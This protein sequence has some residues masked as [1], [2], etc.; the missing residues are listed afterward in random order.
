MLPGRGPGCSESS[1]ADW[2]VSASVCGFF[3]LF[4]V[5][6]WKLSEPLCISVMTIIEMGSSSRQKKIEMANRAHL[7][8]KNVEWPVDPPWAQ[9]FFLLL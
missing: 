9:I 4:C 5:V 7:L 1:E 2:L 8:D 6:V 3:L